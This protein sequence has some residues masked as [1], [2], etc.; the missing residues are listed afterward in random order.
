MDQADVLRAAIQALAAR[1]ISYMIVGS[2]ASMGY[3][4]PRLTL[5]IDIAVELEESQAVSLCDAFPPDE[6]YVSRVAARQ[7]AAAAGQFNVV[8][9][10]SG[11]KI[12]FMV[13]RQNAW[14]REGFSRRRFLEVV[15]GLSAYV[16]SPED[17][18]LGKLWY[19]HEGGSEKHIRDIA[20]ILRTLGPKIDRGYVSQW[21][22]QM[23]YSEYWQVAQSRA[24]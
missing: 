7:A 17:I 10:P 24:D 3:G 22:N 4:E 19:Y 12:D 16:A 8:H 14:D 9:T 18:I 1:N 5:D 21:A 15:N 11:I 23:G 13:S 2:I 6:Y 20:G